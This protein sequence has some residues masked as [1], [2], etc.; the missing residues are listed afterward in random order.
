LLADKGLRELVA[1]VRMLRVEG[2]RFVLR[3][4]GPLDKGNPAAISDA[5]WE[6]WVQEKIVEPLGMLEDV[7]PALSSAHCVV[8]PS[9]REG[10]PPSLLEAAATARPVITTDAVGCRS[11]V[12]AGKSGLLCKVADTESLADCMRRMLDLSPTALSEMGQAGRAWVERHFSEEE[13][14]N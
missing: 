2:R 10:L 1:A 9:Y 8:L 3:V 5:E 7:R 13:V 4:A 14:L 12:D 11:A 6:A